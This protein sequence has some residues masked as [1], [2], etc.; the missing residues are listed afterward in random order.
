MINKSKNYKL[1]PLPWS[2]ET[3]IKAF[4]AN[5]LGALEAIKEDPGFAAQEGLEDVQMIFF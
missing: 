5:W 2:R 4:R 3:L 1:G